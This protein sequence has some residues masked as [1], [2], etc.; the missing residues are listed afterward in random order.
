MKMIHMIAVSL[1]AA[2]LAVLVVGFCACSGTTNDPSSV[3]APPIELPTP[4]T[5][6]LVNYDGLAIDLGSISPGAAQASLSKGYVISFTDGSDI[7]QYITYAPNAFGAFVDGF[8]QPTLGAIDR[9][10]IPTKTLTGQPTT[11]YTADVD[12]GGGASCSALLCGTQRVTIDFTPYEID[13]D[14]AT[15]DCSGN[16]ATLPVCVR[17]WLDDAPFMIGLITQWPVY[18]QDAATGAL[19]WQAIGQGGFR[20][21]VS[22]YSG[23]RTELAY[24]YSGLVSTPPEKS[25]E[26]FF[27]TGP[28]VG[29]GGGCRV[30]GSEIDLWVSH[31]QLVQK[32][33]PATAQKLVK[34]SD[35]ITPAPDVGTSAVGQGDFQY[36]GRY[37]EG[38]NYW[39]GSLRSIE[40]IAG[41]T[42]TEDNLFQYGGEMK[43]VCAYIGPLTPDLFFGRV[44]VRTVPEDSSC[45]GFAVGDMEY[46]PAADAANYTFPSELFPDLLPVPLP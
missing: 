46:I 29:M 12:F 25:V 36:L 6:K 3:P 17:L 44:E 11:V 21:F 15:A 9:I 31:S 41:G 1:R 34:M 18:K 32:G 10:S 22:S 33:D 20:V 7:A 23:C 40:G 8:L 16:A 30:S 42:I 13:G 43:N 39:S 24:Q 2:L 26:Y 19:T 28:Q 37:A 4:A 14:P 27:S 35:V 5:L 38:G 45:Y